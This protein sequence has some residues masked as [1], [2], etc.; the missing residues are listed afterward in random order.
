MPH[1]AIIRSLELTGINNKIIL[2]TKK[3]M[4]YWNTS[5]CLHIERKLTATEEIEI[6]CGIFQTD[7]LSPQLFCN[8]FIPLIEQPNKL[9]TGYE[10][11]T[12][13]TK[14]SNLLYMYNLKVQLK[15]KNNSKNRSKQLKT[16]GMLS[17]C[18]L[19]LTN[20]QRLYSREEN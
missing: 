17:R 7:S 18:N 6:Q 11:H 4:N 16:S 14:V 20:V 5:M 9:N 3:A 12:T 2:F 1:S 19:N 10:E 8:S 15:Q 13:K